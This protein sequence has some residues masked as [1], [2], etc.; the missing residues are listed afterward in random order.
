M[1]CAQVA[2]GKRFCGNT[3]AK[4]QSTAD[5]RNGKRLAFARKYGCWP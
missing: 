3:G 1:F 2:S 5:F 4:V